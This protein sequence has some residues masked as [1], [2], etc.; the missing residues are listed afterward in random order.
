M[1]REGEGGASPSLPKWAPRARKGTWKDLEMISSW[2]AAWL[3]QL[4][5]L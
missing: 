2:S 3:R 1:R 5:Q 4:L